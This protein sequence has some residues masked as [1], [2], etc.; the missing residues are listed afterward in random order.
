MNA[1][2]RSGAQ[3]ISL[4]AT[5][6]MSLQYVGECSLCYAFAG[7]FNFAVIFNFIKNLQAH[8]SYRNTGKYFTGVF[9]FTCRL[10]SLLLISAANQRCVPVSGVEISAISLDTWHLR[11]N[12]STM[13]THRQPMRCK[14]PC[15]TMT[16]FHQLIV[17]LLN[18]IKNLLVSP[19]FSLYVVFKFYFL[20]LWRWWF[21]MNF[22]FRKKYYH[23]FYFSDPI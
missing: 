1:I 13:A 16:I 7:K 3:A 5:R 8:R 6:R 17:C 14:C 9:F 2:H 12:V 4:L 15:A 18:I 22:S 19:M 20:I 10:G 21:E 11:T 23:F